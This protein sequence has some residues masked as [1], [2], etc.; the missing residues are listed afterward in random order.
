MA[1]NQK[2]SEFP[3]IRGPDLRLLEPTR[4]D[5]EP[6]KTLVALVCNT[7]A[8]TTFALSGLSGLKQALHKTSSLETIKN[9]QDNLVKLVKFA[10]HMQT[11]I[12]SQSRK[13]T[14]SALEAIEYCACEPRETN[15]L[16][17]DMAKAAWIGSR[18]RRFGHGSESKLLL[19]PR[20]RG[21]QRPIGLNLIRSRHDLDRAGRATW[22]TVYEEQRFIKKF[23]ESTQINFYKHGSADFAS[24]PG[25][26]ASKCLGSRKHTA[27]SMDCESPE[28]C[29]IMLLTH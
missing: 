7:T 12:L 25:G 26:R 5:G 2:L 11:Q 19:M 23:M 17:H 1:S 18:S 24:K 16:R 10:E 28:F 8:S 22:E 29:P 3:D 4:K 27:P 20:V 6:E 9:I 15:K 14:R 21:T 13:S